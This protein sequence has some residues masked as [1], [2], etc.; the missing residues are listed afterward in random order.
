MGS[1]LRPYTESDL[2]PVE[3]T[4]EVKILWISLV[5]AK[6]SARFRV[7]EISCHWATYAL[8][9]MPDSAAWPLRRCDGT[10]PP[11]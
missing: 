9:A 2:P 5:K 3:I 11:G 8:S 6:G 1:A 7:A 4:Q 10:L